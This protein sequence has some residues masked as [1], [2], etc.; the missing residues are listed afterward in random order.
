MEHSFEPLKNDLLLRAAWGESKSTAF[1]A[2]YFSG[3]ADIFLQ[4][5]KS[6]V[7]RCG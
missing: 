3:N 6:S 7:P 5:K 1:P 4:A 2:D